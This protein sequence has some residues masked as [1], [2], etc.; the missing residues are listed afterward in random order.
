[1]AK[2]TKDLPKTTQFLI[3]VDKDTKQV[4]ILHRYFPSCLIWVKQE[5]PIRFIIMDWYEE[6]EPDLD[7]ILQMPFVQQAK[8]FFFEQYNDSLDLN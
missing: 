8:D 1:M 2:I 7:A 5:T 3:A 6:G 4:Y